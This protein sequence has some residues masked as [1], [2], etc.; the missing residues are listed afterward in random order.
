MDKDNLEHAVTLRHELHRRR[1]LSCREVWTKQR[2]I[3]FL[4]QNTALEV[5]DK[6][7][8]FYAVYHA[9]AGRPNIAFRADFDALPIDETIVPYGSQ[10]PGVVKDIKKMMSI[11]LSLPV[12]SKS[13]GLGRAFT[14]R[15]A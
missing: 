7:R 14:F 2:L 1:E 4:E 5:V 6:G 8:W 13:T 11:A 10:F 12:L 9:G 3:D 15:D